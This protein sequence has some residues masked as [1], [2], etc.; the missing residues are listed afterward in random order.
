[1]AVRSQTTNLARWNQYVK[2]KTV[3]KDREDEKA[4]T[5]IY[6]NILLVYYQESERAIKLLSG[7]VDAMPP[8]IRTTLMH[9]WKQ[10]QTLL[11][12]A[13][14]NGIGEAVQLSCLETPEGYLWR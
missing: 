4:D 6:K 7:M 11:R 1:M 14:R 9:R 8:D 13:F 10:I 3:D 2:G 5:Y 12:A